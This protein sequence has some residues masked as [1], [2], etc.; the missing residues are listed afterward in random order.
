[1]N[2]GTKTV[3]CI[4]GWNRPDCRRTVLGSNRRAGP[5]STAEKGGGTEKAEEQQEYTEE[6][7]NAYEKAVNEPDLAKH[8]AL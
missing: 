2:Q 6:E 4:A 5:E 7:Y 1:M 8:A 3:H